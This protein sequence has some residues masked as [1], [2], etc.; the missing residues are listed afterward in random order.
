MNTLS[1]L[2]TADDR[3]RVARLQWYAQNVVE[4]LHVGMHRSPHKGASIEFKE[5][6]SYV[7]GDEIRLIDWKLFGK[8][9]RLFVKQF[10]DET[11][12]RATLVVDQSRSMAFQG[13]K[14]AVSKH[15]YAVGLAACLGHLFVSQQDAIALATFD[16]RLRE[17]VPA[18]GTPSHLHQIHETLAAADCAG[19]TAIG[20]VLKHLAPKVKRRGVVMLI[21]DGFD[22][23]PSLLGSLGLLRQ[24]G[25]EVVF[26]QIWDPDELHFPYLRRTQFES[27]ESPWPAQ[28]LNP[29][30]IR[31]AYLENLQ[32]YREE[33]EQGCAKNRISLVPC[34]TSVPHSQLLS[35]FVTQGRR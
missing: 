19:E 22:E 5:H 17:F 8:T 20:D 7:R 2:F 35:Q 1:H 30:Q 33:L 3:D 27:L 13:Q 31:Q 26:F 23:L 21:S 29:R 11:N 4:G 6:R 34:E 18:R 14:S 25:N 24:M 15:Q 12:L 9:D 28:M 16:S 32:R 10:E